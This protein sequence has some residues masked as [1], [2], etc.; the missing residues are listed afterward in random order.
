MGAPPDELP[1]ELDAKAEGTFKLTRDQA[2]EAEHSTP[3]IAGPDHSSLIGSS[4]AMQDTRKSIEDLASK[5]VSVMITGESG[6][7]KEIVARA[8]HE[9]GDRQDKPFVAINM[10][11]IPRERIEVTLFGYDKGAGRDVRTQEGCFGQTH[12]GTLFIDE[13]GDMPPQTQM[14]LLHALESGGTRA[15]DRDRNPVH[16]NAR[17]IAATRKDL[18]KLIKQGHFRGDLYDQLTAVTLNLPPLRERRDDIPDLCAYFFDR[19]AKS[20]MPVKKLDDAALVLL[21]TQPWRGNVREL[22]NLIW[23]LVLRVDGDVIKA[24][25]LRAVLEDGYPQ[26]R[27]PKGSLNA[28]ARSHI[29]RYFNAHR[30]ALPPAG[31]Y[32]RIMTEVEKPLLEETLKATEGNQLRAAELLGLNRNTL[33][34]KIRTL[35]IRLAPKRRR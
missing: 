25:D 8:L 26:R 16:A 31:V 22:E 24:G 11:A 9:R 23:Q 18:P 30:D 7:G 6:T 28:D 29:E 20:G 32:A 33:R 13:I 27:P 14:R 12:G 1:D 3:I 19:A 17:I 2:S 5:D 21:T 4:P 10:A 34:K 15:G 35:D